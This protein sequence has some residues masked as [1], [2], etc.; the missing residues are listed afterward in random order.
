MWIVGIPPLGGNRIGLA[1]KCVFNF[2]IETEITR[3][4]RLVTLSRYAVVKSSAG[5]YVSFIMPRVLGGVHFW[6]LSR[7]HAIVPTL[8]S[9]FFF[10]SLVSSRPGL[11]SRRRNSNLNL[12]NMTR[13]F[14]DAHDYSSTRV[15]CAR[16][17]SFRKCFDSGIFT[18]FLLVRNDPELPSLRNPLA[19]FR[20]AWRV[21]A[22]VI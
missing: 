1:G 20:S 9:V 5:H 7:R 19:C 11:S 22:A 16:S 17:R 2:N 21:N 18:R 15:S 3:A 10:F 12:L 6:F 4:P 13:I 8:Q 14:N